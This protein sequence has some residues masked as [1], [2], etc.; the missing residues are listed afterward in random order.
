MSLLSGWLRLPPPRM[1]TL[2]LQQASQGQQRKRKRA[3]RRRSS[4]SHGCRMRGICSPECGRDG[5]VRYAVDTVKKGNLD[6]VFFDGFQG[7][8]GDGGDHQVYRIKVYLIR[9]CACACA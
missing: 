4:I 2:L 5:W 6:G 9:A 7:C 3:D 8:S 1:R